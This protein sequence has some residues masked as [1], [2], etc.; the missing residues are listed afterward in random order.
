MTGA[1]EPPM[2]MAAP[3]H[4]HRAVRAPE[5]ARRTAAPA[6]APL[7]EPCRGCAVRAL[8]VCAV[9]KADEMAGLANI[10]NRCRYDAGA[11]IMM[12]GDPADHLYNIVG[13]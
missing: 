13:A 4:D 6:A 5:V 9:L 2:L 7:P 12:E 8:S 1:M 11:T 3:R 10:V